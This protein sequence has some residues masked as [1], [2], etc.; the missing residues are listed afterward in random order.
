MVRS[1]PLQKCLNTDWHRA[2]I[3]LHYSQPAGQL[4]FRIGSQG[5]ETGYQQL[6]YHLCCPQRQTEKRR[7][8]VLTAA[9]MNIASGVLRHGV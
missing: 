5:L 4:E 1:V 2:H 8:K 6:R 3:V 9:S 7:F